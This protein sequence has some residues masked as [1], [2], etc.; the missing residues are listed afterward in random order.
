MSF[1]TLTLW[2][3]CCS[4]A[5]SRAISADLYAVV[6]KSAARRMGKAPVGLVD[7]ARAFLWV[8]VTLRTINWR[9]LRH[10]GRKATNRISLKETAWTQ[11]PSRSKVLNPPR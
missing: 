10:T 6:R 1:C 8:S 5:G 2:P 4:N 7:H 9:G 11:S 3:V